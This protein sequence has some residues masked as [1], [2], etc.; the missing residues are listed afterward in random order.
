MATSTTAWAQSD[1]AVVVLYN[2]GVEAVDVFDLTS[3]DPPAAIRF[4]ERRIVPEDLGPVRVSDIKILPDGAYLIGDVDARGAA[5]VDPS[6]SEFRWVMDPLRRLTN[7]D[8]ASVGSYFAPGEPSLVATGDSASSNATLIST[9][10]SVTTWFTTLNL[11]TSAAAVPQVVVMPDNRIAVAINWQQA[12]VSAIRIKRVDDPG[13]IGEEIASADYLELPS[14]A[15]VVPEIDRLRD[16]QVLQDGRFLVTA[17]RALVVLAADGTLSSLIDLG[18]L[19]EVSGELASV[20]ATNSGRWAIASFEPGQWVQPHTNHRI[21]WFD[22]DMGVVVATSEPLPRAPLRVEPLEGNGGTG[23]VGFDAGL[24]LIL[25]ADPTA[26]A[27]EELFV[28]DQAAVGTNLGVTATVRNTGSVPLGFERLT[29]R[30]APGSCPL[31]EPGQV[32]LAVATSAAIPA[33]SIFR[34]VGS[35]FV[36]ASYEVGPWCAFVEALDQLG[37]ARR[38]GEVLS[39]EITEAQTGSNSIVDVRPIDLNPGP[40]TDAGGDGGDAGDPDTQP[41]DDKGCCATI[42]TQRTSSP[43]L[44]VAL[45]LLIARTGRRSRRP[46]SGRRRRRAG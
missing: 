40:E 19:P 42:S 16:L 43:Y 38:V 8:S 41:P 18:D 35:S 15:V 20:R 11:P 37:T 24:D 14:D 3:A 33:G 5:V 9:S 17:P 31:N 29:V 25:Q 7:I 4:G 22:P 21:H 45:L 6:G 34:W 1:D 32:E 28:P 2:G 13:D 39:F 30:A 10:Q 23:T 36:D 27:L 12:A 46:R 26:V 44:V